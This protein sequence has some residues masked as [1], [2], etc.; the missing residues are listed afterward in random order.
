VHNDH[1]VGLTYKKICLVK[2]IPNDI[3]H[4]SLL[5]KQFYGY[6]IFSV[7]RDVKEFAVAASVS[8]SFDTCWQGGMEGTPALLK[9]IT[10]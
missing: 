8:S 7:Q 9:A 2:K 6:S 1:K 4:R 10:V 5:V 3:C